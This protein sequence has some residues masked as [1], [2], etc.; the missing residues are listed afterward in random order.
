MAT[1]TMLANSLGNNTA[2][3]AIFYEAD[4]QALSAVFCQIRRIASSERTPDDS[5][6]ELPCR[7]PK[8]TSRGGCCTSYCPTPSIFSPRSALPTR[9]WESRA[10]GKNAAPRANHLHSPFLAR[11]PDRLTPSLAVGKFVLPRHGTIFYPCRR[12]AGHL[13]PHT[14][15]SVGP[16]PC[17][18]RPNFESVPCQRGTS[19]QFYG[20]SDQG[21]PLRC[22]VDDQYSG[23]NIRGRARDRYVIVSCDIPMSHRHGFPR[24]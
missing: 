22:S 15:P 7:I 23:Q 3:L 9:G 11:Q 20:R 10:G 1:L 17:P 19:G 14:L 13:L 21:W 24:D 5:G 12:V 2:A 16:S 6:Q 8:A 4:S 18:K